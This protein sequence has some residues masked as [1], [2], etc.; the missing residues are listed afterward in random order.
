MR[1]ILFFFVLLHSIAG[2]AQKGTIEGFITDSETRSPLIGANINIDNKGENTDQFGRF[3][4]P[5][6]NPGTYELLASYIGYKTEIIQVE[7]KKNTTNQIAV[8]MKKA[9]LDLAEVKIGGKKSSGLNSLHA[10]D[11]LLRP[12]QSSQDLLRFVPG[13]FI[14]QHA[15]GGKAEQI[16]LR[17][18][19]IDH[20]TDIAI[21]VDG[22]PVNMVSH[23]HG[24]G[25]ADLHFV[26]PETVEKVD[27]DKGPY[28]TNKGNLATAGFVDF[29]TIDYLK[30]NSIKL[31]A[32]QF[33]AARLVG[34]L[35]LFK[36]ENIKTKQQLFVASEYFRSDGYFDS[37][38]NFHRF[39][40]MAKYN[41]TIG[42]QSQLTIIASHF[43]SKWN[44]SGQVPDRAVQDGTISRL[45]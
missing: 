31:E 39:N 12:V 8:T 30:E 42:N 32:G 24:Q 33:N 44:A 14:A 43:D 29:R 6:I 36:K 10:V 41:A 21:G 27:F 35:T 4:I 40:V 22:I 15:G 18:Y 16:F 28:F 25:Y 37:P 17:G 23:A 2:I 3:I 38:Q 26:I 5:N 1:K 19:D 7:V 34:M 13:L 11:I 45:Q 20:G 9:G